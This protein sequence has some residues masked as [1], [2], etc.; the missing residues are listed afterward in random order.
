MSGDSETS[1]AGVLYTLACGNRATRR[2]L[3]TALLKMFEDDSVCR[4][5]Q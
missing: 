4:Q 5:T 3:L 1:V 2:Y